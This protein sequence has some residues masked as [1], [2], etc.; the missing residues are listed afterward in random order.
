MEEKFIRVSQEG[1]RQPETAGRRTAQP[2]PKK[3]GMSGRAR[4]LWTL[5]GILVAISALIVGVYL[6]FQIF[7]KPPEQAPAPPANTPVTNIDPSPS[8]SDPSEEIPPEEIVEPL[9]R[10]KEVYTF[11]LAATD[12]DGVR[13]DTMMVATFDVPNKKVGV[14]SIPR[15]TLTR[16]ESG[17]N[18]KLVYGSGNVT[19]RREDISAMLGMPIDYYVKVNLNAF[20]E[21]VDYLGGVDFYVPCDMDYDDP[22]QDLSIHYKEGMQHLSGQQAME[23]ARFRKNNPDENGIATGYSDVG[24]TETQQK[25]L[26]ALAKKVLSWDSLTKVNGFVEIFKKNVSTNMALDDM[27]YFASQAVYV[28]LSTGVET[29]TLEGR[30]DAKYQGHTYC[31]E[32]DRELGLNTINRLINP[33]DRAMT[34]DDM[35]L[36]KAEGYMF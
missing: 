23:V 5:Y 18:P 32:V 36:V 35:D 3:P 15:D 31:Y 22:Y 16:R 28:D 14:V 12:K 7:V 21:L 24:R 6:A 2:A 1:R 34:L 26:I 4:V 13:T 8:G 33:Y 29:A 10:R 30:G 17:K 9:I 25:L 19:Q 11:L 27:L 20:V